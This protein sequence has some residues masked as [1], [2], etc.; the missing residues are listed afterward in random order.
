MHSSVEKYLSGHAE[1]EAAQAILPAGADYSGVVVIPAYD[2]PAALADT[3]A[4]LP[5]EL[6]T[7]LVI[8][9]PPGTHARNLRLFKALGIKSGNR[10]TL[11]QLPN[12]V[13][14]VDRST[15]PLPPK[16]GVGLA[17]KIGA[18]IALALMAAG[19]LP[20]T[21]IHST[22]ADVTLPPD[23]A[24]M[25]PALVPTLAALVYPFR[26]VAPT[27]LAGAATLYEISLLHYVMGLA[28]AGSTYAHHTIGS[29]LAFNP[30]TYA[31][32]RGFPK[33]AAGEDFYLLNKLA[34]LGAVR[35]LAAAVIEVSG[36]TSDR[37]PIGTGP[38]VAK[39]AAL[40]EPL[41]QYRYYAPATFQALAEV[42]YRLRTLAAL[43]TRPDAAYFFGEPD[44]RVAPLVDAWWLAT[45]PETVLARSGAR[46][47]AQR[48][49]ILTE[50]FD[51]FRTMRFI[52]TMREAGLAS[53]P[54]P[55]LA[56]NWGL[57]STS[58]PV[59]VLK[60]LQHL[61]FSEWP[62]G[63]ISGLDAGSNG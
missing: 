53:I 22:D 25:P 37:V 54:L 35:Q 32:V 47:A 2:E 7:I 45:E 13:L 39:I 30:T 26:H 3:L 60:Y 19:K 41:R 21:W 10:L 46:S 38:N 27:R 4:R 59:A 24:L 15:A 48:T 31:Q 42:L 43:D 1:A 58:D 33:R 20:V 57:A 63:R 29:T 44:P 16:Q 18:D 56:S 61:T 40:P 49:R 8:N 50:W 5:A 14:V 55:A 28:L 23:Y 51:G 36:R 34:K 52:H 17:R 11:Q 62:A 12:T 6:L 9:A